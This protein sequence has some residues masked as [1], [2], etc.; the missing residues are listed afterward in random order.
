MPIDF[1]LLVDATGRA[2]Q[3]A[4]SSAQRLLAKAALQWRILLDGSTHASHAP[5]GRGYPLLEG[6]RRTIAVGLVSSLVTKTNARALP[7]AVEECLPGLEHTLPMRLRR[8]FV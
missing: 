3:Y 1:P 4:A 6:V 7:F 2:C 5:V 8:Q